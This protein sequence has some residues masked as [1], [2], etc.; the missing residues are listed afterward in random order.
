MTPGDARALAGQQLG[1]YQLEAP[2]PIGGFPECFRARHVEL[3]RE[4]AIKLLPSTV[5]GGR[6]TL[7]RLRD[8]VRRITALKHPNILPVYG[9]AD[10][11]NILFAVLPL[12][13]ESLQ[14]RLDREGVLSAPSAVQLAAQLAWA[15]HALHGI[16]LVH[17][18]VRPG[19]LLFDA[20]GT[21]KLAD[22]GAGRALARQR[23]RR[24]RDGSRAWQPTGTRSYVAP[25]VIQA[26]E[27]SVRSDIY[28]LGA[29]LYEMLI[30]ALPRQQALLGE[31][32]TV[33]APLP[34]SMRSSDTWPEI[35]DVALKAL[36]RDPARRYADARAFAIALR[37][38]VSEQPE[39]IRRRSLLDAL[40]GVWHPEA[41]EA[42]AADEAVA[43]K[44]KLATMPPTPMQAAA[45]GT[46][47]FK[48]R[49]T[50]AP[51][52]SPP[53]PISQ[54]PAYRTPPPPATPPP[55]VP[56]TSAAFAPPLQID[57][58]A[59]QQLPDPSPLTV[60]QIATQRLPDPPAPPAPAVDQMAT[61]LLPPLPQRTRSMPPTTTPPRLPMQRAPAS[62]R[63]SPSPG[64][65]GRLGMMSPPPAVE[66][67]SAH[68]MRP[69]GAGAPGPDAADWLADA[70]GYV[71]PAEMA[72][73]LAGRRPGRLRRITAA[74]AGM[75]L[76]L[77]FGAGTAG[78]L[79]NLGHSRGAGLPAS[80][81]APTATLVATATFAPA[82]ATTSQLPKPSTRPTAT[83]QPT[84]PPRPTATPRP[85][86]TPTPPPTPTPTPS[87]TPTPTPTPTPPTP[88]PTPTP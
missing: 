36:E 61:Q 76:L 27:I 69:A 59:T 28:A 42:A 15:L 18:D 56:P 81:P 83:S 79:T 1:A 75:V 87:P 12:P 50:G 58:I 62:P 72:R 2:L 25:E 49:L 78:I 6:D 80:Q 46:P 73:M 31:P 9:I 51:A 38:A 23:G 41:D 60:E 29:V 22:I 11:H 24:S 67:L 65:V 43:F 35:A 26:G 40:A 39:G 13:R 44:K 88:P 17:G 48:E 7:Q 4:V 34:P 16:G 70:E 55:A 57:Q 8:E 20:D 64:A 14:D 3:A 63:P 77:A 10:S 5:T 47:S 30:G 68:A 37:R 85:T 82:T 32:E 84:V 45:F 74:S 54:P 86:P 52:M 66:P 71:S 53:P 33:T 19:M 21:L